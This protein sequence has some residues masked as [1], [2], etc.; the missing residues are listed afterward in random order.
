MKDLYEHYYYILKNGQGMDSK[1]Y[2][3]YLTLLSKKIGEDNKSII[4]DFVVFCRTL[5]DMS[6]DK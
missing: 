3:K 4:N 2:I 6:K 1:D 5:N